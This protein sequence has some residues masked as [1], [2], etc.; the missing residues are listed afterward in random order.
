MTKEEALKAAQEMANERGAV[1]WVAKAMMGTDL[2]APSWHV[3]IERPEKPAWH[4]IY[5][6]RPKM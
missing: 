2:T 5:R 1:F 6:I 3:L 4:V